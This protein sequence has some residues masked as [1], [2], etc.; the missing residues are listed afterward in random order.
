MRAGRLLALQ[1]DP[2]R[3][4]PAAPE[5][6]GQLRGYVPAVSDQVSATVVATQKVRPEAVGA[7]ERWQ[8][9]VNEAARE[10]EGFG[11]VEVIPPTSGVPDDQVVVY[12]FDT[13]ERLRVWLASDRRAALV[14]EAADLFV[15]EP[16]LRTV[17]T[18]R[19]RTVTVLVT[20]RVEPGREREYRR[21]QDG[22]DTAYASFPGFVSTEVFE[23]GEEQ[24]DWVV[25]FRFADAESLQH[26]L[27]SDEHTDDRV[28]GPLPDRDAPDDP[29]LA[30]HG[31]SSHGGAGADLERGKCGCADL[32]GDAGGDP[33]PAPMATHA[34]A[35]EPP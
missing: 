7:Y 15:E 11:G 27:D 23:P 12:R 22:I 14:A 10:F 4:G 33:P 8:V 17:A 16:V 3:T 34:R 28:A 32:A 24:P 9:E 18:P 6:G 30:T 1:P 5:C 29:S 35:G 26:W 25:V 2:S 13:A 31:R 19:E 21:W 20:H